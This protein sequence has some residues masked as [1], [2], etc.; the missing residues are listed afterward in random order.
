MKGGRDMKGESGGM[1]PFI[2]ICMS[3]SI[4]NLMMGVLMMCGPAFH[5]AS[6]SPSHHEQ[7]ERMPDYLQE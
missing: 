5:S 4:H 7:R 3:L 1:L 6:V 2:Y